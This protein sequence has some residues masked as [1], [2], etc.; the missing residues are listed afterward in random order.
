MVSH[1]FKLK[2]HDLKLKSHDL[3]LKSHDLI[4]KS[5]DL[6][7]WSHMILHDLSPFK[8]AM[9]LILVPL[10]L[11]LEGEQAEEEDFGQVPPSPQLSIG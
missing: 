9:A 5:H 10:L 3:T 6:L 4:L 2:S 11:L 7:H 8:V 1:D